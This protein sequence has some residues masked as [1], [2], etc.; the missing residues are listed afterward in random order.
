MNESTYPPSPSGEEVV[1]EAWDYIY[2]GSGN[3]VHGLNVSNM[4]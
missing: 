4:I 1:L 3:I 2:G